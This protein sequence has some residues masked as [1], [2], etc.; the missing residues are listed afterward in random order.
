MRGTCSSG[1]ALGAALASLSTFCLGD[2]VAAGRDGVLFKHEVLP[3]EKVVVTFDREARAGN[4]A[5]GGRVHEGKWR[6]L[7]IGLTKVIA[8]LRGKRPR[9]RPSAVNYKKAAQQKVANSAARKRTSHALTWHPVEGRRKTPG[10]AM[11][12][13]QHDRR[14]FYVL[15]RARNGSCKAAAV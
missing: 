7:D 4:V 13:S 15:D 5:S 6:R 8:S 3:E 10:L 12:P 1:C 11:S 2:G 9:L 14:G